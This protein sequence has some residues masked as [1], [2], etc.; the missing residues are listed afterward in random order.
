MLRSVKSLY[1]CP[2]EATD[3]TI[4]KV[5]EFF[6]IDDSWDIAYVVVRTGGLVYGRKILVPPSLFRRVETS[7][8]ITIVGLKREQAMDLPGIE[9]DLP[10]SL[11]NETLLRGYYEVS[12]PA[13]GTAMIPGPVL[14][15]PLSAE[16][17]REIALLERDRNLHLRRTREV[18]RYDLKLNDRLQCAIDDFFMDDV[19]WRIKYFEASSGGWMNR[20]KFLVDST[21]I[22]EIRWGTKQVTA[23]LAGE[24][25]REWDHSR[26]FPWM[27]MTEQ[28]AHH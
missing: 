28:L 4:G 8:R 26:R 27:S 15:P 14:P 5:H 16:E 20:R 23:E 22:T 24:T 1:G 12:A 18:V 2:V 10:V 21:N 3:G 17:E 13:G 7:S 19:S 11:F 9:S 6:F 25:R